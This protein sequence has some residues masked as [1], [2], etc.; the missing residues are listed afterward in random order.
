[1]NPFVASLVLTSAAL[2]GACDGSG[3]TGSNDCQTFRTALSVKDRM[4]QAANVFNSGES[5]TFELQITNTTLA[6]A[7]LTAGSSCTA[8]VFEVFD[9]AQRR[10]WGSA[11]HIYCLMML[12]ARTYL[13]LET[14]TESHTWNQQDSG[15]IQVPPGSYVVNADVGQ[16]VPSQGQ[17]VDCRAQLSRSASLLIQ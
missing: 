12:Q 7:T 17:L 2:T 13:P 1:M 3:G 5:V 9:A 15:G 11:D 4:S 10:R 16:Y 6:P 8:V 14:V